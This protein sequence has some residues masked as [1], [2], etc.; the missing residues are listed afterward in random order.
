MV[1]GP[2]RHRRNS[3]CWRSAE[4][5]RYGCSASPAARVKRGSREAVEKP[6]DFAAQIAVGGPVGQGHAV[7]PPLEVSPGADL[8]GDDAGRRPP[9][10][11]GEPAHA[12]LVEV[13]ARQPEVRPRTGAQT[14]CRN[15]PAAGSR[16]TTS[17]RRPRASRNRP[18][19]R[20][21]SMSRKAAA[22][23]LLLQ[24]LRAVGPRHAPFRPRNSRYSYSPTGTGIASRTRTII[25]SRVPEKVPTVTAGSSIVRPGST[26]TAPRSGPR[27]KGQSAPLPRSTET[28]QLP[29]YSSRHEPAVSGAVAAAGGRSR[30]SRHGSTGPTSLP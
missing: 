12:H 7:G 29:R 25:S 1:C 19:A 5:R 13:A 8:A 17:R 30:A 16:G 18:P 22:R 27:P 2:G 28:F 9:A 14:R 6:G 23:E 3:S 15:C 20:S 4:S 10:E 11:P 21:A 24:I 26:E